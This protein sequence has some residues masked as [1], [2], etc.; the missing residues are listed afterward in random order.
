MAMT[1]AL[2]P[3]YDHET[4]MT[5][6]LLERLPGDRLTWK[7]HPRSMTLGRLASHLGS[8][9]HWLES[10]VNHAEYNLITATYKEA[11]LG[12][13]AEILAE[14]DRAAAAGR[15]VLAGASDAQLMQ[16]WAFKTDGHLVFSLPKI[17]VIRSMVMNHM[18]HHRGQFS[19]YLR[20]NDVPL[21]GIYGPSADER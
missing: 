21:P 16:P 5:R 3:E 20:E 19:V 13:K 11:D 18:I 15:A 6:K 4:A 2:L 8:L 12:S 10:A 9:L 1:D 14:F 7:P 17:A